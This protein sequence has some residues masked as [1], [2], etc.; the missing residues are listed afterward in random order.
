MA[1]IKAKVH[2]IDIKQDEKFISFVEFN[3]Y[4]D[5][6]F[7]PYNLNIEC[8]SCFLYLTTKKNNAGNDN[9]KT[10]KLNLLIADPYYEKIQVAVFQS[11]ASLNDELYFKN[12]DV[13][14]KSVV[15]STMTMRRD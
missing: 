15:T 6:G 4:E 1:A 14:I 12:E 2:I 3:L 13:I 5:I 10:T 11:N 8:G 9:K 7:Y